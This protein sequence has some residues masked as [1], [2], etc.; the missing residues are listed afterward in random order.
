LVTKKSD[1]CVIFAK[2]PGWLRNWG[3]GLE[4]NWGACAPG[5]GLKPSLDFTQFHKHFQ[6]YE[7]VPIARNVSRPCNREFGW[8]P[9]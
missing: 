6:L 2:N 8:G 1:I 9:Y 5:P 3:K 4:Q 7:N